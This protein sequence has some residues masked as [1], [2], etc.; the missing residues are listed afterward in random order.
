MFFMLKICS[1]NESGV[2][3]IAAIVF[4]IMMST[5]SVVTVSLVITDNRTSGNHIVNSQAFWLA[6]AGLERA[7]GWLRQ[8]DPPPG[9]LSP[10]TQYNDVALGSGTYTVV[11]DPDDQN[12]GNYIKEYW[13]TSTGEVGNIQRQIQIKVKMCTFGKYTYCTNSEGGTVWFITGDV[14]EGPVH[15]NDRI[16]IYESPTFL[17]RVTSAAS[18]FRKGGNYNPTFKEGYQLNAPRIDFPTLQDVFD[19]YWEMNSDP[20]P[21]TIDAR[22]GR[23]CNIQFNADGTITFNVWH[24][25]GSHKVYDIQDSTVNISDLN[26][27][28]YVQG[29]VQIAGTVNGVVTL[30]ATD[31]IKIIDDVKYQD[32]DSYGR[33]TSDCDDALAL[34]S[35]KDIVVAD[36]PANHDDCIIDAAL[37]ALDSS[38]YVENYSS[39]S[40][41]GYLRVWGSISQKVRGP[42]GTFSWWGRTGYSK[43][44]HYDQRFE[45]TPPPY[46][47]TTGNYEISMWKELTP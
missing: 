39:G 25:Q 35:A 10:F 15:S 41:R 46:Y 22:F 45:Q 2:S 37:L 44:Y 38:F 18:S 11:I 20:P 26:G 9:G 36:T 3:L 5:I 1:R 40:P 30:I 14:L 24:W 42:V 27:I 17:G 29:D 47:P 4:T 28:I 34:I 6:E 23:D 16:S 31:D 13:I 32:S 12:Q 21:L 7:C 8:Q 19:N 43:D 33:P